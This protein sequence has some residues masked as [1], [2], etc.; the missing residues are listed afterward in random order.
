MNSVAHLLRR[1]DDPTWLSRAARLRC[2][3]ARELEEGGDYEA[4]RKAM[5]D[6]WQRVG[7]RPKLDGLDQETAAEVL[8][9]AGS[10]SG[11]IGSAGQTRG[12]QEKAKDLIGESITIL[13]T[14]QEVKKVAEARV[15]LALCYWR[16]G[17]FDEARV[18]LRDAL[19]RL[20]TRTTTSRRW[21]CCGAPSSKSCGTAQRVFTSSRRRAFVRGQP[22]PHAQRRV[23]SE[24]RPAL[25]TIG[26]KERREA[27]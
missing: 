3:A 4:A 27:T 18:T 8:L 19:S 11:W 9:R 5:G 14:L 21:P 15:D 2:Q 16:E 25:R 22:Q 17:A 24:L 26:A 7:E 13:E 1:I 10:L 12:A 20:S 6:L 23:S